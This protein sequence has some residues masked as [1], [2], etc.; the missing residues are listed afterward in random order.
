M[1]KLF[2]HL[3]K[4]TL[5]TNTIGIIMCEAECRICKQKLLGIKLSKG[6]AYAEKK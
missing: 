2:G 6:W 4:K 1:C 3:I 5:V